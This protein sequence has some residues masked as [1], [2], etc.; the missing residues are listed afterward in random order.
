MTP[1]A[2]LFRTPL[3][4]GFTRSDHPYSFTG[5][6]SSAGFSR[7]LPYR[8]LPLRGPKNSKTG[9]NLTKTP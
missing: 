5:D 2:F 7:P 8:S 4:W 6:D 1:Y 3:R 9:Y